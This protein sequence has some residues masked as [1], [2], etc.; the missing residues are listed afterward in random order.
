MNNYVLTKHCI[1]D[2]S[3]ANG[4]ALHNFLSFLKN[5]LMQ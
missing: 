3:I 2:V 1:V 5:Y 4:L